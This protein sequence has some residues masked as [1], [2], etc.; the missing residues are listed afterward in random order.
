MRHSFK[1]KGGYWS[2]EFK[3]GQVVE[4]RI[5]GDKLWIRREN[6][7]ELKLKLTQK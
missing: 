7:K 5:H 1:G 2:D 6:G 4:V 3:S